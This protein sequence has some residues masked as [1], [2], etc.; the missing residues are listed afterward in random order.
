MT[1]HMAAGAHG[2]IVA[3]GQV[4]AHR[5]SSYGGSRVIPGYYRGTVQVLEWV[6]LKTNAFKQGKDIT[7]GV[8][9]TLNL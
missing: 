2:G 9:K 5:S 7:E 8:K 1:I 6:K 3:L 4:P